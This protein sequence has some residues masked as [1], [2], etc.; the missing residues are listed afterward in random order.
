MNLA[1]TLKVSW[2][3]LLGHKLRTLL[4][5]SGIAIGVAAVVLMVGAG[6]A[7]EVTARMIELLENGIEAF[8]QVLEIDKHSVG[9]ERKRADLEL[10]LPVMA[11][12]SFALPAMIDYLMRARK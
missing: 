12:K 7:A 2:E 11:M 3:V 10:D 8:L 6:Q 1:R 5:S 9:H 4:S